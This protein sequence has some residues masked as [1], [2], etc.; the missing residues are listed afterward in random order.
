MFITTSTFTPQATE[1]A[2]SVE[3]I[4]LVNGVKLAEFMVEH[5]IG[6]TLRP[7]SV[8]KLDSSYFEE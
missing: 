3:R 6:V 5:G 1:F 8:P 4:V 2:K 7:L